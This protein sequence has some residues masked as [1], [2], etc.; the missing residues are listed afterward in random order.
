MTEQ[1]CCSDASGHADRVASRCAREAQKAW[2]ALPSIHLANLCS[3]PNKT[4]ELLMLSRS[5]KDFSNSAALCFM[6]TWVNDTIPDSA[7]HLPNFQ[8][9]RADHKA[10]DESPPLAL[11]NDGLLIIP[12]H[13]IGSITLSPLHL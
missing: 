12:I 7:L 9:F 6:E 8:L 13:L 11:V 10:S 5:N 1:Q 2:T 3:L 4:D